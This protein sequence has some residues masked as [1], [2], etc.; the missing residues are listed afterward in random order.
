MLI[1]AMIFWPVIIQETLWPSALC[2]AVTLH[3]ANTA[4]SG[5]T[6]EEILN[7]IKH[8]SRLSDF[9]TFG[10]PIFVLDL[11]LQ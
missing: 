9:V 2:F 11:N 10:C 3:N 4:P 1:H 7:G 5:L 8:S 6:P